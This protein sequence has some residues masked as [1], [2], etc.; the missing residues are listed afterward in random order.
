MQSVDDVFVV[1]INKLLNKH[2]CCQWTEMPRP[3]CDITVM[4]HLWSICIL[5]HWGRVMHICVGNLTIIGSDNSLSPGRRQAMTWTNVGILLIGPLGTNFSEMLI[6][7][8]IFS[9]KKKHLQIS[10]AKWRPLC[11]S[12]N[13]LISFYTRFGWNDD[14][15][16]QWCHMSV[17]L[18]RPID[19]S[20]HQ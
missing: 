6:K 17:K 5:T 20:L 15:T 13:V 4:G 11:L 12:L 8:L 16:S 19:T 18:S 14:D 10:S 1:S 3:S 9:F 2:S 7:I